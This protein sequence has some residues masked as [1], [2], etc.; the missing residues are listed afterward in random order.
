MRSIYMIDPVTGYPQVG[1]IADDAV[2]PTGFTYY[3]EGLEP[4]E[5][6]TALDNESA[7]ELAEATAKQ[8]KTDRDNAMLAG[9]AYTLNG[10]VY[11]VS[12]TANDGNGMMQVKAG[13][14]MGLS[15]T[16]IH[17]DNGTIVP[18]AVADFPAFAQWFVTERNKFF[19]GV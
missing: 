18:I 5:L 6:K 11:Q 3:T 8:A 12:L 10:T 7:K 14:D 13:F 19:V 4:L 15:N 1:V 9:S 16:N 2:I 17:F